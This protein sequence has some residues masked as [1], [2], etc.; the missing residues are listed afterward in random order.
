MVATQ[1]HLVRHGEV[2][3]PNRVLYG[4]LPE[5]GLSDAGHQ[6]AALAAANLASRGRTFSQLIAS[7]LQRTQES[8]APVS[9]ALNLPVKLDERV[10]EPTNAFEGKRMRGPESA[11]KDPGNWKYL[12]NPFK[13]SWGEPYQSIASR[14]R[15]AMTDA[16]VSVPDGDV[17]IVSHQLPIWMVHR[18]VSG[19]KLF[20]DPRSRRCTLSS[21]TTLELI[22][23]LKP[24]LGFVEVGYVEPASE[25]TA[26]ALDVGAV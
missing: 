10:I 8:A 1:L 14:M 24:E 25:L 15:E 5:Y 3:N 6:M 26:T 7:P 23:P 20:H 2:Y 13:P 22:D 11:L 12:I 19:K 17:V 4:R 16:A 21:I 9:K 18:D